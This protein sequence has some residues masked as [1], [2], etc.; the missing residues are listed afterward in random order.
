MKTMRYLLVIL[1][2]YAF[3][4]LFSC[5]GV[6]KT[7]A[8]TAPNSPLSPTPDQ[9]PDNGSGFN[10]KL[11]ESANYTYVLH[12]GTGAITDDFSEACAVTVADGSAAADI[13][14]VAEAKELDL[15]FNGIGIRYNVPQNLCDYLEVLTPYFY[16]FQPGSGPVTVVDNRLNS[17]GPK[18]INGIT[19][20]AS[21]LKVGSATRTSI[22]CDTDYSNQ[23]N[24]A[25]VQPSGGPNCCS[26]K[27]DLYTVSAAGFASSPVLTDWGGKAASCLMGPAMQTGMHKLSTSGFPLKTIHNVLTTGLNSAY[28]VESPNSKRLSQNVYA[29]NFFKPTEHPT[30]NVPVA[31]AAVGGAPATN[32]YHLFACKDRHGEVKSRIKLMVREW[33]LTTEYALGAAGDP[34]STGSETNFDAPPINDFQ[35]FKDVGDTPTS[36]PNEVGF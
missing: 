4:V 23:F 29:S 9:P 13:T 1:F 20:L 17:G 6:Q 34:D 21:E 31:F 11:I 15:Y 8:S 16:N 28:I 10:I 32:P 33:N 12:K 14:C 19:A 2:L 7:D 24:P 35:D 3:S 25:Y 36:Y 30:N 5:R 22:Y 26:G 27:Y 18:T